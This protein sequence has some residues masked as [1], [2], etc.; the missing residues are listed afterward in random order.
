MKRIII[1]WTAGRN[2]VSTVDRKHYHFIIGADGH[3]VAG[4]FPVSANVK[5]V[6]GQYAAHTRNA[7]TGSIGVAVAGMFNAKERPFNTG[8]NPM[9]QTQIDGLAELVADLCDQ[10]DIPVTP[11]TVLTHAEVQP[12]LGI[13][14]SGKWD[15]TWLPDMQAPGDPVWVG[16][17]IRAMVRAAQAPAAPPAVEIPSTGFADIIAA[18]LSLFRR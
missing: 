15:I 13:R 18:F 17:R 14:Q 10:Y 3:A 5:P 16:D 1:H 8:P 12:T 11:Q 4:N 6:S 9:T 7:N 2:N